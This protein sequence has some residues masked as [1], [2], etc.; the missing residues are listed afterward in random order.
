MAV[1]TIPKEKVEALLRGNLRQGPGYSY[2]APSLARYPHQWL[3]DSCFHAIVW[4]HLDVEMAKRELSTLLAKQR[5]GGMLPHMLF[6]ERPGGLLGALDPLLRSQWKGDCSTITQPPVFPLAVER[7]F[8]VSGDRGWLRGVLPGVV[9]YLDWLDRERGE[10]DGLVSIFHPWE[11]LD[12]TPIWDHV[13]G[14]HRMRG[15]RMVRWFFRLLKLY[16][17]VGYDPARIRELDRFVV[18][19]VLFNTIYILGLEAAMRLCDGEGEEERAGVFR[20]R[21]ERAREG[22]EGSCWDEEAGF[23]FDAT[24]R[25]KVR[26]WTAV[27]L[28]PLALPG[29]PRPRAEALVRHLQDPGEFGLPWP[30][31]S[32][33]RSSPRFS[34]STGVTSL[35]R[36]LSWVHINWFLARGLAENAPREVARSLASRT[37]EMVARGGFWEHYDPDTGAGSGASGFGWSTLAFDLQE[38]PPGRRER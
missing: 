35:F 20:R 2:V 37:I 8:E 13:L 29:L 27:G 28:M 34:K 38:R 25:G 9:S 36:G 12:D 26:E 14:L 19:D 17:R 10:P 11:G 7:V 6:W 30:V 24:S 33:A 22:L 4:C 3:W 1:E 15:P 5:P 16:R 21:A 23:Y 32:A 31:P 18:R